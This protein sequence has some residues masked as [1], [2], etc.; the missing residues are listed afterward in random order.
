MALSNHH[1]LGISETASVDELKKAYRTKA[2]QLHPDKNAS[3]N[4]QQ[5]FIELTEAYEELLYQKTTG[6]TTYK[7]PFASTT[8]WKETERQAAKERAKEYAQ[9]R[10]EEFEKS[11]AAHT[12]H[13]LNTILNHFIFLFVMAMLVSLPLAI[14]YFYEFNGLLIALIFIGIIA[15]PVFNFVKHLVNISEL[16]HA[17]NKITETFFFR[18]VVLTVTNV[19]IFFKVVMNTLLLLE[20]SLGVLLA[21]IIGTFLVLLRFKPQADKWFY[22]LCIVP[23]LLNTLYAINYY[24]GSRPTKETYEFWNDHEDYNGISRKNTMIHLNGGLYEDFIGIRI[25]SSL[26]QMTNC[27]AIVYQFEEGLFGIRVMRSYTFIQ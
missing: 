19:F 1:T 26:N 2:M 5:M 3:P 23:L 4:A 7:A 20:V 8:S 18:A 11:D 6:R 16:W 12:I 15:M 25:F 22:A 21:C 17:V 9:M 10:Y 24:G 27:N 14:S 13:S